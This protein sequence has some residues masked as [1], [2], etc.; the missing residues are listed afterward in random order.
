MTFST[1]CYV[2]E[3]RQGRAFVRS[4]IWSMLILIVL[5]ALLSAANAEIK[6]QRDPHDLTEDSDKKTA[7]DQAY[8]QNA[9]S[10]TQH[11]AQ[12]TNSPSSESGPNQTGQRTG[13]TY[14]PLSWL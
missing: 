8:A 4:N 1:A 12:A 11:T 14:H 3:F 9:S 5:A 13:C 10:F 2:S 6:V 7:N